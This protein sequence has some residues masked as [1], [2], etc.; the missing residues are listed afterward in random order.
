MAR[1]FVKEIETAT[2]K[3]VL[4]VTLP[5]IGAASVGTFNGMDRT[6]DLFDA[7]KQ[8]VQEGELSIT[9]YLDR[10]EPLAEQFNN[11]V[12]I[13]RSFGGANAANTLA[14][15]PRF[16]KFAEL[17]SKSGG[18]FVRGKVPFTR[19]EIEKLPEGILPSLEDITSGRIPE[20]SLG[21][22][23]L[24]LIEERA[25]ATAP[26]GEEALAPPAPA[27][28]PAPLPVTQPPPGGTIPP[29]PGLQEPITSI[30]DPVTGQPIGPLPVTGPVRIPT[31]VGDL[32]REI[33]Q[34]RLEEEALRV[35]EQGRQAALAQQAIR[36]QRL[37]DLT[38]LLG[39]ERDVAFQEAA[40]VIGESAQTAGLFR[41]SG[42]GDALAREKSRLQQQ[43]EF[44][45]GEQALA[46]RS[47]EEQ[48]IASILGQRQGLQQAGLQRR[49]SFEDFER[50]A[51]LA[52][53]LGALGVP[54]NIQAPQAGSKGG[55]LSGAATGGAAG[56]ILGP[57]GS[58]AGAIIGGLRG[59]LGEAGGGK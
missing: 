29:P 4:D 16:N 10:I 17:S 30:T 25:Q 3:N 5:D 57:I 20:E 35:A 7:L 52:R 59:A 43:V 14:R 23:V 12:N 6:L 31:T 8:K 51:A 22:G 54:T 9:D 41:S 34:R 18:D 26:P 19:N 40:P 58:G 47:A 42:F 27:P 11:S 13:I 37:S 28:V 55:A 33:G 1:D 48:A 21:T 38:E 49:F 56:A 36:S 2:G 32:D 45:L 50:Q 44:R 24:D 15:L 39:R 46:D 53:E